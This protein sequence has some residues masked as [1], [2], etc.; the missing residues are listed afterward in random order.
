MS[1]DREAYKLANSIKAGPDAE[2]HLTE[3]AQ[4]ADLAAIERYK[5]AVLLEIRREKRAK[6]NAY[7]KTLAAACLV[8]VLTG[9]V[10]F[11]DEVYAG[12]RR[13]G[14]SIGS[15]LG[16][17]FDLADY[18]EVINTSVTD[19][20][21][22]ITMQEALVTEEKLL[23]SYTLERKDG[24][25]LEDKLFPFGNLYINGEIIPAAMASD[26][27]FLDEEHKKAGGYLE[28]YL[29][30][31]GDGISIEEK[32]A[33]EIEID[34]LG[35]EGAVKGNWTFLFQADG[36]DLTADTKRT[37]ID[38]EFVLPDGTAVTLTE[39]TS[40]SFEQRIYYN[41]SAPTLYSLEVRAVDA[42]GNET[43]FAT[44]T[45]DRE[46]GYMMNRFG[47]R[48]R[49]GAGTVTMTVYAR[50][51]LREDREGPGEFYGQIDGSFTIEF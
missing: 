38:M 48:L 28:F 11:G 30:K 39:F 20:G 8:L 36:K 50:E 14:L 40:N 3:E 26:V 27:W 25:V 4:T 46:G 22:V 15:A 6:K 49:E 33:Y 43:G 19:K 41:I 23:V 18:S 10:L 32:N 34:H 5:D 37:P 24:R 31:K 16:M 51:D 1:M 7:R 13:I 12:V 45:Q 17:S 29:F 35:M 9:T 21:Y 44:R 2:D 42:Q 47:N